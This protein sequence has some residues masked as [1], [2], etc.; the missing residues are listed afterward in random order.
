MS[1]FTV[2]VV[3]D[4]VE[5]QLAPFHEFECTGEDNE[6]VQD[7]DIT[8][9]LRSQ[10]AEGKSL[11]EALEWYGLED[12]VMEDE[13][14]VDKKG[15]HK[16]GYVVV[17]Q[18]ERGLDLFDEGG[19]ARILVKAVNRTNPNK[20]WDWYSVGGRWTGFW[21]L[22]DGG[23]GELGKPGVFDN[24]PKHDADSAR[25]GDIDFEGMR[26]SAREK[27]AAEFD[28][29]VE[30]LLAGRPM[31]DSWPYVRDE[32]YPGDIDDA[33]EYYNGQEVVAGAWEAKV[34][35]PWD[36]DLVTYYSAGVKI[37]SADDFPMAKQ[38]F[39]DQAVKSAISTFAVLKDGRWYERG[40]MGWWACVS[41]EKDNAVWAEEFGRLL[42]GLS[43]DTL[44]TVVDCHI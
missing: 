13:N 4:D 12:C 44:L 29:F 42:D 14:S 31:P 11:Q 18:A 19:D 2:L 16:Y 27:A 17:R 15:A 40:E 23:R 8:E 35:S 30:Y 28:K 38:A 36:S 9:K 25:K 24:E 26:E 5:K 22:K 39:I 43:D 34:N 32:L 37:A 20:K 1:H 6:Y 7:V 21:K 3:G 10:I 33:R 41:G